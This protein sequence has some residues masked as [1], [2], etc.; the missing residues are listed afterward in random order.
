MNSKNIIAVL[1]SFTLFLNLVGSTPSP[2][3][4]EE[5]CTLWQCAQ[6]D[7][8]ALFKNC[9]QWHEPL[10]K[11]TLIQKIAKTSTLP[12]HRR[13][14]GH[15]LH[16]QK[17]PTMPS[18]LSECI[19]YP[20]HKPYFNWDK[21]NSAPKFISAKIHLKPVNWPALQFCWLIYVWIL[22]DRYFWTD[23]NWKNC[24]GNYLIV[25]KL[26]WS[27]NDEN[28]F[29]ERTSLGKLLKTF[30]KL[31]SNMAPFF[32]VYIIVFWKS[33]SS[34]ILG[35]LCNIV[36]NDLENFHCAVLCKLVCTIH[37]YPFLDRQPI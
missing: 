2:S 29:S 12:A 26:T 31:L 18:T 23:V 8:T 28:N 9:L 15:T 27:L 32:K 6:R 19:M 37:T 35:W 24:S 1:S 4:K 30:S 14:I 11:G 17:T 22:A 5:G 10:Q 21:T 7:K 13:L 36:S 20:Q 25:E 16:V 3:R 33:F 34:W